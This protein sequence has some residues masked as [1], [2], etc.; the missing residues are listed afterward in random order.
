MQ[1]KNNYDIYWEKGSSE[2]LKTYENG[3]GV[4]NGE[5]GRIIKID[6]SDKQIEVGFDDGKNCVVCFF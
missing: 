4:F 6:F 1:I 2:N 3:T 5:I